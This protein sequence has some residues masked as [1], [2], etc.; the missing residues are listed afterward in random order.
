MHALDSGE[1]R[2]AHTQLR[3]MPTETPRTRTIYLVRHGESRFNV[4]IR[5]VNL[6]RMMRE[7]DHGLSQR[8]AAQCRALRQAIARAADSADADALALSDAKRVTLGSPLCRAVLTAH[9]ALPA[10]DAT[11]ISCLPSAREHCMLP[12]LSRDSEGT[13]AP[14]I[15]QHVASELEWLRLGDQPAPP[16]PQL[17]LSRVGDGKWW[18]V[19]ESGAAV[20]A[21]LGEMLREVV[22]IADAAADTA[23][24]GEA[25]PKVVLVGHSQVMR[26]LFRQYSSA[27]FASTPIGQRLATHTVAN[28]AVVRV[29]LEDA[30]ATASTEVAARPPPR[31]V[32]AA[33]LFG[34]DF[35]TALSEDD[36]Q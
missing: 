27:T 36:D 20:T 30:A 3:N 17:D 4:A 23:A 2:K 15:L 32:D 18:I 21:R 11:S 34:T 5:R 35:D 26:R 12:L 33:L 31:V 13:T 8:G 1:L 9:L 29:V 28:C 7:T 25:A 16:P 22:A 6:Y 10:A 14:R 24:A 19:A